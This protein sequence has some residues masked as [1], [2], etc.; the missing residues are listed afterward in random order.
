M[1]IEN[2]CILAALSLSDE[3]EGIA[4]RARQL[5]QGMALPLVFVHIVDDTA[6]YDYANSFSLSGLVSGEY[7]EVEANNELKAR[8]L[9]EKR[10][11]SDSLP[12]ETLEIHAGARAE[13]LEMLARQRPTA[14]IVLGQPETHS[15]SV[16]MHIVRHAPCDIHIVRTAS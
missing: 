2:G 9:I 6:L 4:V 16:I 15:G 10:L 7:D 13:T 1:S 12:G 8:K 5:A 11:S 14:I 3:L